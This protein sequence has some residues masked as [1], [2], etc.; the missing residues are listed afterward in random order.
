M[1]IYMY[2]IREEGENICEIEYFTYSVMQT[3]VLC[4][5]SKLNLIGIPD[6]CVNLIYTFEE[7]R[8]IYIYFRTNIRHVNS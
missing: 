3:S 5:F 6:V 1:R 8:K 4:E 2:F 7:V